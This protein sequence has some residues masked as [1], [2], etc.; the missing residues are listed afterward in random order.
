[1]PRKG[2]RLA[3]LAKGA[4]SSV[5]EVVP[6]GT[7]RSITA[8]PD[9]TPPDQRYVRPGHVLLEWVGEHGPLAYAKLRAGVMLGI[10]PADLIAAWEIV[11][12]R[13][14]WMTRI[15][16]VIRRELHRDRDGVSQDYCWGPQA[17]AWV[18]E[19][20]MKDADHIL[21]G[22]HG[23]EFRVLFW[24][25]KQPADW[26]PI[27]RFIEEPLED[28]IGATEAKAVAARVRAIVIDEQPAQALRG[29][30]VIT[31]RKGPKRTG[32]GTWT[33]TR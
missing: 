15:H 17:S 33:S 3:D 8:N 11:G 12:D 18:Q 21:S 1:M 22:P 19:V 29:V 28:T 9:A 7:L 23:H 2:A 6:S 25:G 13:T 5:G 30:E 20:T 31:T 16:N 27:T 24:P 26:D 14:I 10:V 4:E 32:R